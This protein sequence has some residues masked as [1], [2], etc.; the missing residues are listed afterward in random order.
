[1]AVVPC[2]SQWAYSI[3]AGEHAEFRTEG[4]T[5]EQLFN[6]GILSEKYFQHQQ[7]TH[8]IFIDFKHAFDRVLHA[9]LWATMRNYNINAKLLPSTTRLEV[10]A[11]ER[12]RQQSELGKNAFS[13]LPFSIF[14][15]K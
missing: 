6:L 5:I 3:I 12:S 11:D 1:M 4:N 2:P 14:F 10:I 9:A 13:H 8:Y 7:N 15:L